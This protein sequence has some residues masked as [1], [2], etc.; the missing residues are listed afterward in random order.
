MSL[1]THRK[2]EPTAWAAL[3][4]SA[5]LLG[6]EILG[7]GNMRAVTVLPTIA[8]QIVAQTFLACSATAAAIISIHRILSDRDRLTGLPI[9]AIALL[10]PALFAV[11]M[12]SF[13]TT[14]H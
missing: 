9:A 12:V 4:L 6:L 2:V 11:E 1:P 7:M 5:F 3:T 14:I 10:P 13:L 8:I